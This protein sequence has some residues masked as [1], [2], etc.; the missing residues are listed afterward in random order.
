M[1]YSRPSICGGLDQIARL[2]RRARMAVLLTTSPFT[3][4]GGT[5]TTSKAK[6][7]AELLQQ[8]KIARAA[9]AEG[10]FVPDADFAQ[11]S[12]IAS[13]VG[14]TNS[15]GARGGECAIEVEDEQMRDAEIADERDL[16]LRRGEQMRAHRPAAGP[17]P[18]AD[19]T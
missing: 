18:D 1:V 9:F 14:R 16:V 17:S 4:T 15:S 2:R 13:P 19:R 12:R 6:L 7:R 5:P 10:P 11:R 8:R 3:V